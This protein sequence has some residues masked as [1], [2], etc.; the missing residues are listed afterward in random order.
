MAEIIE[1]LFL[2]SSVDF[3]YFSAS[4]G[5]QYVNISPP[6]AQLNIY[7]HFTRFNTRYKFRKGDNFTLLSLGFALPENFIHY[8]DMGGCVGPLYHPSISFFG[9]NGTNNFYFSELGQTALTDNIEIPL[10]NY[11]NPVSVFVNPLQNAINQNVNIDNGFYINGWLNNCN[12]SMVNL[13]ATLDGRIFSIRVF[14][15]ISHNFQ[16]EGV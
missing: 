5:V 8:A 3:P 2:S 12:I 6:P 7:P 10:E 1:T 15:K 11:E 16:L 4:I 14:A 13:P 9:S